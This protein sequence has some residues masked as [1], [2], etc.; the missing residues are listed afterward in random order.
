MDG[1]VTTVNVKGVRISTWEKARAAARRDDESMGEWLTKA[2]EHYTGLQAGPRELPP[3]P[4]TVAPQLGQACELLHALAAVAAS[5]QMG[6]DARA[7]MNRLAMAAAA[8]VDGQPLRIYG[9]PPP[10]SLP[11]APLALA[12]L[13]GRPP[14]PAAEAA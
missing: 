3:E 5:G 12:E 13:P 1:E 6:R 14:E 4:I 7:R 8:A 11:A 10:K 2:L 9:K